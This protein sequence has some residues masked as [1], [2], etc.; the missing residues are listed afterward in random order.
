MPRAV[1]DS[2]TFLIRGN[3]KNFLN[4][5]SMNNAGMN[6]DASQATLHYCYIRD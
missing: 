6:D 2:I 3:C 5:E 4:D 1:R